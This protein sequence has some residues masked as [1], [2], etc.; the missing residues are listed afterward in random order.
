METPASSRR[1]VRTGL[2][3]IDFGSGEVHKEGRKVQL[4]EQ[5]FRVLA[6]L[7]ECPGEVVT[8]EQLQERLW[9]GDTYV[10]FDEGLNTAIRKLR[11]AFGD[12]AENPR[13]IETVSRRGYRFIAPVE[14]GV[15]PSPSPP[16]TTVAAKPR[17]ISLRT[18]WIGFAVVVFAVCALTLFLRTAAHRKPP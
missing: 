6:I 9:S 12:S 17:P 4:Q 11:V 2:F 16:T 8:R 14:L 15:I 7:L 10:G 3:E 13:F 18:R 1:R 5:P